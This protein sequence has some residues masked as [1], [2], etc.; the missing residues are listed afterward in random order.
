MAEVDDLSEYIPDDADMI[1]LCWNRDDPD[2]WPLDDYDA[3]RRACATGSPV[4]ARWSVGNRVNIPR[5]TTCFL[6]VQGQLHPRGLVGFAVTTGT[7][8]LDEHWADP[9]R[10]T[11]YVDLDFIEL[12][13]VDDVVPVRVLDAVTPGIPW[14]KGIRG[15]GF[16]VKP[17]YQPDLMD[18]WIQY[19]GEGEE[20]GP[21]EF[22]DGEYEEGAVRTIRV[23]RYERD[24]L[25]RKECLD[26]HGPI[27]QACGVDLR[28]IYGDDLGTR[29]IHVHHIRPMATRGGKPYSLNAKKDLVPLCPNCH[30]VI[31]KFDPVPTP[32]KFA[33]TIRKA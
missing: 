8:Y 31:H 17:E 12:L 4:P 28:T 22:E 30:N 9:T 25:A 5:G 29:A 1:I 7:P 14:L 18:T 23:N 2:V 3:V 6:L 21:G 15:S 16:P 26:F 24:P 13:D 33:K 11:H 27:C 32:K 10:Q 20:R 19:C